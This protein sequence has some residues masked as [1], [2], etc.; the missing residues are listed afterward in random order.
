M[1]PCSQRGLPKTSRL[2]RG[3]RQK[4]LRQAEAHLKQSPK[5]KR[6]P[7]LNPDAFHRFIGPKNLGKALVDDELVSC[8]LDN[9]AQLNFI[10]P[11]YAQERG[12]DIM[13]LDYLAKEIGG[14]IPLIRGL[15]GISV[16]PVG[17][18]M[19]NVKVPGV[20]GYDEDQIAIVMDDPGMTEWPVILGTPTLYRVM[21]VIKESEISKLAVPWA[22]SCVSWLMRD[23][24]AKLG[25]V[26]VNDIANKP[27]APLHVD[28]VVRVVSKCTVPP[29]GHK[30]IH[31]KVNLVLH[32]YKMNV[33]TH[34]LEKRSPSLP[35]GIDVQTVYATL[36]DG[37]N[38]I[39]V[40]L[41]NNTRDWIEIKKGMPIAWMV[42]TNEVPKVTN[43][44][45]AKQTKEQSTL[46]EMERQDLLLE[47]LDLSGL[48]AWSQEQ[49]EQA[50]S[51]LKEYHD[52]FSLEKRDMGHTN[53][54]KHKIVLKDPDT[55]PFKEHFHRILPPQLD[56][57]REHLKLMLDAGVIWPSNSPWCNAVV[58]VR[59]KDG[60]LHFCI[61]FRRLN[62]LT[63]KDSYPLPCI[64]ETLESLAGTA[65]YTTIDMNSGFWQVPM[66]EESKQ[67]M[68]FTL[69]SM[70]LYECESMPFGLCNT[71]PTFQRLMLNC[72]GEL[73]LT[74]CLIYLDD[75]IIFSRTEEEHLER[76]RVV[77]DRFCEHGLKLKPSKCEVFKTKINYLAHH[78]S[79]R[80]VLPSKK[81]LEAIA[82]CPP[83]DTYTKVKSFVGLVGHYRHFIKG[84]TNIAA[85]LYNL[86]SG[87]N[88]DKKSEHVDLS[89]EAREAFDRLKAA[90]LQAPILSFPD[91]NKPFLLE[92]E[93]SGRGLGAVLSQ[94]QADGRYHPIAYASCVMNETEQR[95][96]SNKQEFLALKWAVTEQFHEYLSPYE[97]NWNEFVVRTDNNPLTYIFSSA[98]LDA[99]GQRWVAHLTSY[100]FSLEYQK[101]KDNT[102][103]N[104][105]SRMNE[106]L[107]EEEVQEYLNQIPHPGVKAVLDNAITPIKECAEQGVRPTPDCQEG[108][109]EVTV[110]ARPA[111]L[112]TTNV[113]DWK[114]EQKEDPVL[115]QVAK[116]L[117]VPHETFK[118]TLHKVLDKKATAAYVKVKQQLLIKNGLLYRKIWRGQADEIVFQFVV[119]QRH[120]GAALDGCH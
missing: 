4:H 7:Y 94:K 76:I 14:A 95:Y 102:V 90:C 24:L 51:L 59:K 97:K 67:Y 81:N 38:R 100:N 52:I 22:S 104:F 25:Q 105:L 11:A 60:S 68:A 113:T 98:N 49:A 55:P 78:I 117:R 64:C 91:F 9:G 115:Y 110:E 71:P 61:D 31:G 44:F 107:P 47:K 72:L 37:S 80:G 96:H 112:A 6:A 40:V 86:T 89:P 58:L 93:A 66:D 16:E 85:P 83:P 42:A 35:L 118:A 12:M 23:V 33:M 1:G 103:A 70:G 92:T 36:A 15:G 41:R 109:Q 32:G 20:E 88:E 45:S 111:R 77:F 119:P 65:H 39:T 27:I 56:E 99:A 120:R 54:T 48:E 79:K 26:V 3:Q 69:G 114:Q 116:H 34:G 73:N 63:V 28:E 21:E 108:S 87:D 74:Y 13:S 29:F 10:M 8:L 46:T 53:T 57:V 62:S 2:Q 106:R 19:M 75:V 82:Q 17:F 50:H 5:M 43:L 101:G 18:V 84:F 30:A